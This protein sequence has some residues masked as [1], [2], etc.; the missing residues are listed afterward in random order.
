M[1]FVRASSSCIS[2][3][4][5]AVPQCVCLSWDNSCLGARRAILKLGIWKVTRL[6]G[7]LPMCK[8]EDGQSSSSVA[9]TCPAGRILYLWLLTF[10]LWST[11]DIWCVWVFLIAD[12]AFN[13]VTCAFCLLLQL[14]RFHGQKLTT[15]LSITGTPPVKRQLP[16]NNSEVAMDSGFELYSRSSLALTISL[17]LSPEQETLRTIP[18]RMVLLSSGFP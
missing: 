6:R 18:V 2:K 12:P 5:M 13:K 9:D 1:W 4:G 14:L 16:H 15:C 3:A 8:I 7:I 11:Y 17:I 10:D